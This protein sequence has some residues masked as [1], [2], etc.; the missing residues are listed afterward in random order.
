MIV[1]FIFHGGFLSYWVRCEG[2]DSRSKYDARYC[3]LKHEYFT[4]LTSIL[5]LDVRQAFVNMSNN[6]DRDVSNNGILY[7]ITSLMLTKSYKRSVEDSLV[8]IVD[9]D[10]RNT[11]AWGKELF[12]TTISLLKSALKNKSIIVEGDGKPYMPYRISGFLFA[13]QVWIYQTVRS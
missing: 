10:E 8:V 7:L 9:S 11:Y 5:S 1:F 6:S 2:E 3:R 4:L 12:R 13:F